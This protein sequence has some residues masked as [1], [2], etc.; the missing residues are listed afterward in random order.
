MKNV[1]TVYVSFYPS[2][3]AIST[4]CI[5]LLLFVPGNKFDKR[6]HVFF[7]EFFFIYQHLIWN[8]KKKIICLS[9]AVITKN[10]IEQMEAFN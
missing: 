10:V 9:S 1:T 7:L 3:V 2:L 5:R 4:L 8:L 6:P